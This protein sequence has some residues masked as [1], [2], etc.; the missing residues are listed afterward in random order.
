MAGTDY[1]NTW[2]QRSHMS[3]PNEQLVP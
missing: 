2:V 1:T 3:T